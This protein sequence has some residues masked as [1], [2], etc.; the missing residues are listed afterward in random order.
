MSFSVTPESGHCSTRSVL[1]ICANSGSGRSP[2]VSDHALAGVG[3]GYTGEF[4][5]ERGGGG[6]AI[7]PFI[8]IDAVVSPE[9]EA[10]AAL[11]T[12][13]LALG[14]AWEVAATERSG[15]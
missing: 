11:L 12:K 3:V 10:C 1:R 14:G 9:S 8:S 2:S 5:V 15:S 4:A 7:L 13:K 6:P